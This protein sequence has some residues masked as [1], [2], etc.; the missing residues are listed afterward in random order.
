VIDIGVGLWTLRTTAARPR[1]LPVSYAELQADARLIEELG[2]HSLWLAEHHFWY[3]GWCPAPVTAAAA[4]LGATSRLHAGTGVHLLPMW[5]L[6][7]VRAAAET[8]VRLAGA[9]LELGVGLGYRDEEYVGFGVDRRRR[10]RLM[11][12][13]LDRLRDEWSDG[14]GCP[15]MIGGFSDAAISRAARRGLGLF[16]PFSL[17]LP[18]L[19]A[20]IGRYREEVD[21]AGYPPGRIGM[22][23]F[24]WATDGSAAEAERARDL[25]A[26]SMREYSG[27]WFPLRGAIGFQAPDLLERQ[28]QLASESALIGTPGSIAEGIAELE[29]IGVELVVLQVTRDDLT[30]DYRPNLEAIAEQLLPA[31]LR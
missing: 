19:A 4:V 31:A 26:A 2:F 11:D 20:T 14:R 24:A 21:T 16:L 3:D 22:L 15:L 25:V 28:L 1:S 23:K 12:E 9:R 30:V 13:S 6:D 8:I 5:E 10:G 27:S 7:S 17:E 29:A 18:R